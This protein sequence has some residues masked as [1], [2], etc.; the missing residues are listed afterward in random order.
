MTPFEEDRLKAVAKPVHPHY[1]RSRRTL[2]EALTRT[3]RDIVDAENSLKYNENQVIVLRESISAMTDQ[4]VHIKRAMGAL[5]AL[6]KSGIIMKDEG[7]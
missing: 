7:Q 4:C 1:S 3:E 6:D 2:Q 5:G